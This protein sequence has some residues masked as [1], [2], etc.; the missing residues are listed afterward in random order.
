MF[1]R[2]AK[3][4]AQLEGSEQL[5][6]ELQRFAV[7]FLRKQNGLR[8]INL[9][10]DVDLPSKY[11]IHSCWDSLEDL[12]AATKNKAFVE[13]RESTHALLQERM[14]FWDVRVLDRDRRAIKREVAQPYVRLSR[15][16]VQ[17]AELATK[18]QSAINVS[19]PFARGSEGCTMAQLYQDV[20]HE[21]SIFLESWWTSKEKLVAATSSPEMRLR[22]EAAALYLEQRI[23]AWTLKLIDKDP[24][25]PGY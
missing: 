2:I 1:Y 19:V 8:W 16:I 20:N 23:D 10:Q 12:Q 21:P 4:V 17:E 3:I 7:E 15:L 14:S 5:R 22:K 11:F 24:N 13:Y 18:I 25:Y 6:A 9:L